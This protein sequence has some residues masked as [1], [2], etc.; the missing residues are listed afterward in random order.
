MFLYKNERFSIYFGDAVESM[1]IDK[2][3]QRTKTKKLELIA[4]QVN[5]SQLIFLQQEHGSQGL[6]IENNENNSYF[7]QQPGDF[8]ITQ[9]K[10]CGIGVVTADCLPIV[11]YDPMYNSIGIVH[12]GWRGCVAGVFDATVQLMIQKYQ[13]KVDQLQVFFGP[14]ARPCCYEVQADFIDN[15][16]K[17]ENYQRFFIKKNN[18]IYFDSTLFTVIF[19]RNLG[20]KLKNIYTTYNVCTIC[21]KSFCSYR[22]NKEKARRQITLISLH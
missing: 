3:A 19:A 2:I 20:I 13:I 15:F 5:C 1:S 18:K 9:K 17:Y 4:N 21:D 12:A 11:L 6:C 8:L 22:R 14:A 10:D 16:K 7:F